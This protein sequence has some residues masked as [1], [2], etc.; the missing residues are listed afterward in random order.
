LGRLIGLILHPV[1]QMEG[2]I[3][4]RL[5]LNGWPMAYGLIGRP[6]SRP[7]EL[8]VAPE[9]VKPAAFKQPHL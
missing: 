6:G 2:Y 9:E 7:P 4:I 3:A 5:A 8:F 1:S